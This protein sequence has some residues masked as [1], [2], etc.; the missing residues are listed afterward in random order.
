M[1]T[2]IEIQERNRNA[3][4]HAG[5][6]FR[7]MTLSLLF[8]QPRGLFAGTVGNRTRPGR[9]RGAVQEK[10]ECIRILATLVCRNIK[11]CIEKEIQN[12]VKNCDFYGL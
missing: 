9:S 5:K 12:L 8:F 6:I 1:R 2:G 4:S 11:F 7:R 3:V 10:T